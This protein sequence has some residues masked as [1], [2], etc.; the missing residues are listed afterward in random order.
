MK[1][2][3]KRTKKSRTQNQFISGILKSKDRT[4]DSSFHNLKYTM[5]GMRQTIPKL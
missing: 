4:L 2:I 5:Q 1:R 3:S